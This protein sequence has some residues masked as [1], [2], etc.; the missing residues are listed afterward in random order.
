M[1][2]GMVD[3]ESLCFLSAHLV[4]LS[5]RGH[6]F[7]LAKL[8][9]YLL[10]LNVIRIV[11]VIVLLIYGIR[12]LTILLW[13]D[14]SQDLKGAFMNLTFLTIYCINNFVSSVQVGF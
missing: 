1:M 4:Y 13:L 11:L 7:K 9:K 6:L 12:Y 2:F 5:I 3:P 10:F 14:L 8:I